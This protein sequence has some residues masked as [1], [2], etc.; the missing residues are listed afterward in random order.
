MIMA[1]YC[2]KI[3]GHEFVRDV[4]ASTSPSLDSVPIEDQP[5]LLDKPVL[6]EGEDLSKALFL[7][8]ITQSELENKIDADGFS[9]SAASGCCKPPDWRWSSTR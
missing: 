9:I 7:F 3:H 6:L 2:Y 5:E 4:V 8:G 1:L